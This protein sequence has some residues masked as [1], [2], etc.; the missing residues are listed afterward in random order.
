MVIYSGLKHCRLMTLSAIT[1]LSYLAWTGL[2]GGS[3]DFL[4]AILRHYCDAGLYM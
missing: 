3:L 1:F 4:A 2:D